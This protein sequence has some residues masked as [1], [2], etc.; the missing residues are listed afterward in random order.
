M[1]N[2]Y[3]QEELS[4]LKELGAEFS[5]AH[6]ALAPMLSGQT[7]DPDVERLLEGTAFLTGMVRQ[8]LDDEFPELLHG[9]MNLFFPHYLRPIPSAS[10]L[11]FTPRQI[12]REPLRVPAGTEIASTP[13][14]GTSCTFRT[15]FDV[16]AVPLRI[17]D[18]T[19]EQAAGL[20]PVI[21]VT[22]ELS[23]IPL[24]DWSPEKIRLY[25]AGGIP[26]GSD[27]YYQLMNNVDK[28][29]F[30]S[31]DGSQCVLPASSIR[32]VGFDDA[33][34]L[35][36]YPSQSFPA[37]RIL[38]EYFMLPEKFLFVDI[39]GFER[40]RTRGRGSVFTLQFFLKREPSAPITVKQDSFV[41]FATPI[42]NLFE[43]DA[44]PIRYD[45]R[46]SRY[47]IR[48]SS[49]NPKHYQ[50]VE[51]KK[52]AGFMQGTSREK[53]YISF[54][55]F[56][57]QYEAKAVYNISI[58]KSVID[59]SFETYIS[60]A[61]PGVET[62]PAEEVL[63]L[64]LLCTNGVLPESLG[65]GDISRPTSTS[66]ELLEFSNIRPTTMNI[67][68][69]LESN[70]LWRLLSHVSI[71]VLTLER[72]EALKT[73]LDLYVFTE[74]RDRAAILANKKRIAGIEGF[75]T[76]YVNRL[77]KGV[78]ARGIAVNLNLNQ[79]HFAGLGDLYLF[80]AILDRFLGWYSAINSFTSLTVREVSS[81]ETY[82]WPARLG[83]HFLI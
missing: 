1:F 18:T 8:K 31:P 80:S 19:I 67:L 61:Y 83:E 24:A 76:E 51:V 65:L 39:T 6:P 14:E 49:T 44:D 42:V 70:T 11:A 45:H 46:K 81:G 13:Q 50:I 22:F 29:M 35:L 36:K 9:L 59:D 68:P 82:R 64:K 71:N 30:S 56:S 33:D 37:Y 2:R 28:V 3:Y 55:Q 79:E 12:L 47:L 60:V 38:Q 20:P 10:I 66:P 15:C 73:L 72:P 52:V 57:P 5:R 34:A 27:L 7:P 74:G 58:A 23:G 4:L 25:L 21:T 69:P 40:W 75:S 78:M 53:A 41:L 43:H 17:K 63:S 54:Q 48:P 77:A 32:P 16:D 62:A 26:L